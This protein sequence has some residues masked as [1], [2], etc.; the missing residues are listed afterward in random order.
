MI[1]ASPTRARAHTTSREEIIV[2]SAG[3]EGAETLWVEGCVGGGRGGGNEMG[4][5]ARYH[6]KTNV[7]EERR[8]YIDAK[9]GIRDMR[10]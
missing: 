2:V 5:D 10:I 6:L 9:K 8:E 3:K 7:R 4:W 1:V